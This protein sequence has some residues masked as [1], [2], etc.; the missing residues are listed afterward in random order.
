MAKGEEGEVEKKFKSLLGDDWQGIPPDYF[1]RMETIKEPDSK[2]KKE[3]EL[4]NDWKN[5]Y[6]DSGNLYKLEERRRKEKEEQKQRKTRKNLTKINNYG[7]I[8]YKNK[9]RKVCIL[10]N[11]FWQYQNAW[12]VLGRQRVYGVASD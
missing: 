3:L 8:R 2:T 1:K 9:R 10:R 6:R 5:Y 11:F 12:V 4:A 7:E